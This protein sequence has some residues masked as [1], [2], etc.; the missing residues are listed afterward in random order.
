MRALSLAL[1]T[2][3]ALSSL[4][5]AAGLEGT[6]AGTWTKNRDALPVTLTFEA[7]KGNWSGFFDSDALQVAGIPLA[8][9]RWRAAAVHWVLHG[10]STTTT[11]DGTLNGSV[12]R[13]RFAENGTL[14]AFVLRRVAHPPPAP[15][16]RDVQ[17]AS[18]K[19]TIAGTLIVPSNAKC[20][21]PAVLF[22]HGSGPEGRWANRY[23][24]ERFAQA[25]FAAL[26]T[27]K[28]G[29]SQST[30]DW[31][32]ADFDAL[33]ADAVAGVRFLQ[34]Q[35][36]IDPKRIGLYGHSQGGTLAPFV[37]VKAG[38]LGFVVASAAGGIDPAEIE[39]YS[40]ANSIGISTLTPDEAANARSF[41]HAIV[42]VAYRR[43]PRSELDAAAAKF[44]TRP[45]YFAPP[46][47]GNY[48]WWFSRRIASY[49]PVLYW[50]LVTAPVL[51]LYGTRDERIPPRRDSDAILAALHEGG[52]R[53]VT[54]RMFQD[55]D[56][57][58]TLPSSGTGW[59]KRVEGYA[60]TMIAW[61]RTVVR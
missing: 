55:A 3:L 5:H 32:T 43:A 12:L 16:S 38:G 17:Y 49:R 45:W 24:A 52:N 61:A 35:S 6:W 25:G 9:L 51:L 44:R 23:L 10:D 40:V 2:L 4:A 20:P 7:A 8:D 21:C 22:L 30:G 46:P 53:Q 58:F 27:D 34:R 57:T 41:V 48:Y 47:A 42:D 13:G 54:L 50:K 19:V 18:G 11:F 39:E 29:V 60:D 56:H 28:R 14:G 1:L 37:A 31:K 15:S 33:A 59:P 26:I 36:D